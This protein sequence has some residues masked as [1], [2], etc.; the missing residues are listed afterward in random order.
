MRV[1]TNKPFDTE[2]FNN[3][4][5]NIP[6]TAVFKEMVVI[7]ERARIC[8][9]CVYIAKDLKCA[10]CDCSF[11]NKVFNLHKHCPIKKF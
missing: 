10:R 9:S 4:V 6:N 5:A 2:V 1:K 8:A 7:K 3:I 11:Y